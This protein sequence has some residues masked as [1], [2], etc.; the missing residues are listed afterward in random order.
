MTVSDVLPISEER[1]RAPSDGAR[2]RPARSATSSYEPE[3]EQI[4]ERLLPVY[5]ETEIYRALLE[6]GRV[7]AGRAD[8]GD[9]ERVEGRRRAD[10]TTSRSR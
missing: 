3:P 1:A 4:L 5:L 9:A 2:A 6:I 8:D 10:R 7:R